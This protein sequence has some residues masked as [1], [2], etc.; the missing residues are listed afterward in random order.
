ML[1]GLSRQ[2][3]NAADTAAA[4]GHETAV[5]MNSRLA[6]DM[7]PLSAQVRFACI[8][9]RGAHARLTGTI[10]PSIAAIETV[11]E[12]KELIGRTIA[13]LR[14]AADETSAGIAD[15]AP[16][17]IELTNGMRFEMSLSEY[18]RSWAIPQFY[19]Y[20]VTAYAILRHNGIDLGKAD[21]VA[22]MF[23]FRDTAARH[24]EGRRWGLT[25]SPPS[26]RRV[27]P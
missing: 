12:A 3:D 20:L 23:R 19:F 9:A 15:D 17:V 16:V 24:G 1:E 22:H 25:K 4:K 7:H 10:A 18:V 13:L 5:L 21:Y 26:A 6:P 27:S 14:Q 2:L 11:P 8:Q